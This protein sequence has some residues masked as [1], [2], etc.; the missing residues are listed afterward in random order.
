[1]KSTHTAE[2]GDAGPRN[3]QRAAYLTNNA[4]AVKAATRISNEYSQQAQRRRTDECRQHRQRLKGA[5]I[6]RG[7]ETCK[8]PL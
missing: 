8:A 7:F 6:I 1:M 2:E 3:P 5:H 4:F